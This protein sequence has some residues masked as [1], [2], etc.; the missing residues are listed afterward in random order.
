MSFDARKNEVLAA[1]DAQP[2]DPREGPLLRRIL[3]NYFRARE[4][5]LRSHAKLLDVGRRKPVFKQW[6]DDTMNG[7]RRV[8]VEFERAAAGGEWF[9]TIAAE[10]HA[11]AL[12][13]Y[14]CEVAKHRDRMVAQS[15]ALE[16][17]K[18]EFDAKWRRIKEQDAKIDEKLK[19]A[20]DAYEKILNESA[21]AAAKVEKDARAKLV[22]QVG[23]VVGVALKFVDLGTVETI[24]KQ[25]IKAL[26]KALD[27][28]GGRRL[29]IFALLSL[30]EQVMA[31]FKEAREIVDEFLADNG[32][33][34]IKEAWADAN[35]AA[36]S[37]EKQ[38]LTDGQRR[39]AAELGK[40]LK[41]ELA[42]VFS[43]AE[44][45]YKD[46]ARQHEH[47]FFG[48]LGSGY[49]QELMEDDR[50]KEHS[51]EWQEQRRDFDDLLRERAL[52]ISDGKVLE[53]SLNGLSEEQRREV[54]RKL[55]SGLR[56]LLATWNKFK[57]MTDDPTWV[58]TSRR[59]LRGVLDSMR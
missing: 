39:D 49:V 48:P 14:R 29:E 55:E 58:L 43:A 52:A 8:G 31:S 40:A 10:E 13:I 28:L 54:R 4:N 41:D 46:F 24:I 35:K 18:K 3:E 33:P 36:E 30:E 6:L 56:E 42:R 45:S 44:R 5:R 2:W 11:F 38:M 22:D 59:Q 25:G 53:V 16:L 51:R 37:L 47:L 23:E 7:I 34:E 20:A 12:R 57:S 19:K 21:H 17:A 9:A 1:F 27:D 32:Y 15:E 26:S 50:W